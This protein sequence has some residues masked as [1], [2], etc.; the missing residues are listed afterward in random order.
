MLLIAV[1]LKL[2]FPIFKSPDGSET[3]VSFLQ[4]LN[5]LAEIVVTPFFTTTFLIFLVFFLL[6]NFI[7]ADMLPEPLIVS[8][9]PLTL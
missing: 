6:P 1:P 5:A 4:S 9:L 7:L 8:V 3:L 2:P